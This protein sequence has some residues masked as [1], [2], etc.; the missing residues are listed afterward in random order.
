MITPKLALQLAGTLLVG[1]GVALQFANL[2]A[3]S[4]ASR[5]GMPRAAAFL[6]SRVVQIVVGFVLVAAGV[7]AISAAA[8]GA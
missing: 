4:L 3:D 8:G 1:A 6:R 5:L 7:R 2:Y